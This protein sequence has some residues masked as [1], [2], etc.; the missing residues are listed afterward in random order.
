MTKYLV[1]FLLIFN[2]ANAQ[3]NLQTAHKSLPQFS[4]QDLI[5]DFNILKNA[6]IET[7]VGLWY[8]TYTQF[9]SICTVQE[10]KIK[11]NMNALE[12]YKVVAPIVAFTKEGHCFVHPSDE[13]NDYI[14]QNFTYFPFVVKIL[15]KKV[16]VINDISNYKTKGLRI[17]KINGV[18]IDSIMEIFLNIEP[19]DGFNTTA[20]YHWIESAFSKYYARF[21][22]L[23]KSFDL[24]LINTRTSKKLVYKNIPSTTSTDFKK[25]TDTITATMPGFV[26]RGASSINIDSI[27]KTATLT[28]NSFKSSYYKDGKQG[29]QNLLQQYFLTINTKGIQHLIIDIRKDEGGT[30]GM[31]DYLLSYLINNKYK[32]YKYVE[33]PSFTYSFLKY[34]DDKNNELE[35]DLKSD[36]NCN[37]DGRYLNMKGHYEG[38][39]A[40]QNNFKGDI[41]I[42]IS[43]LTFSGGSEFAALAKNYTN[44]KFIGEETGG[45]YYG[46]T[47]GSFIYYKLP[48]TELKGRIPLCKFVLQEKDN[49]APFGHGVMPDYYI[50]PTIEDYFSNNDVELEYAKKINYKEK[51]H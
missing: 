38:V 4:H 6:F 39:D 50:Q 5:Q 48:H 9:D 3:Q 7:H 23:A 40:K 20:K 33:I 16:Y 49:S 12:F 30:Q 43:G 13:T 24:E 47:S 11:D 28:F 18:S 10:S 17:S 46:N 31:E 15:E 37:S 1:F 8:N 22:P 44:A 41:Y 19:S 27:Q 21:F 26:L 34:S 51:Y 14:K 25:I 32:K 36:F 42:L 35:N 45:G 29:F 2:Y